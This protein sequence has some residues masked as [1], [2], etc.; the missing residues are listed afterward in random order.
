MA[1]CSCRSWSVRPSNWR[2]G[3]GEAE[4]EE[5]ED[6]ADE[7]E[8]QRRETPNA[9]NPVWWLLRRQLH[10]NC[11]AVAEEEGEMKGAPNE[12]VCGFLRR[13]QRD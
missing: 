8:G 3:C 7:E 10:D 12:P 9:G 6:E 1:I 2:R 4:E 5:A 11:D 13:R